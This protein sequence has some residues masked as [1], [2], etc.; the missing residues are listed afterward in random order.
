MTT[1]QINIAN[2]LQRNGYQ[3]TCSGSDII[4]FR[5]GDQVRVDEDGNAVRN[6]VRSPRR[7]KRKLAWV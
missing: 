5:N 3:V 6:C 2:R 7:R 1:A 4:G